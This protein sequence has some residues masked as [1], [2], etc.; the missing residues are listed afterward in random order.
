[1]HIVQTGITTNDLSLHNFLITHRCITILVVIVFAQCI[2]ERCSIYKRQ[3]KIISRVISAIDVF[4]NLNVFKQHTNIYCAM[5]NLNACLCH[6]N[7]K[8]HS[9]LEKC[10]KKKTYC[11][12]T[13]K[14]VNVEKSNAKIQQTVALHNDNFAN[15]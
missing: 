8:I 5:R 10:F 4:F 11:K 3:A 13:N 2:N 15:T 14:I 9:L 12:I 6:Y 7:Y 1:M